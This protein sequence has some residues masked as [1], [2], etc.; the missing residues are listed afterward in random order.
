MV[1]IDVAEV[2]RLDGS[3]LSELCDATESAIGSGG[4]FGWLKPPP[5][6]TL[7]NFWRGA[8]MVPERTVFIGRLDNLVAGS[9]Q[10]LRPTRNNEAQVKSVSLT[11]NFVA[12]WARGHG[13]ARGLTQA[14]EDRARADGFEVL[15]LDV[16]ETQEAAIAL[17][18]SNGYVRCGEHPRYA[19][20]G[21]NWVTGYY[22]YKDLTA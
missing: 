6:Q 21:K 3:D 11:T 10:L 17:Y 19:H 1:T 13:L 22:Y 18:E 9:A 14:A 2:N 20:N 7:E 8:L 4:G 5:R 15:N 16:R 12:P